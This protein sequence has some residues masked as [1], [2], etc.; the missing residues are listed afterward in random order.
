MKVAVEPFTNE[1]FG[2]AVRKGN[3]ELL[4]QINQALEKLFSSGEYQRL[5]RKWFED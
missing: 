3:T 1:Q 2:I 4:E 5:I